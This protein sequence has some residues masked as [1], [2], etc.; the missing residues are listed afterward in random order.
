ML[1]DGAKDFLPKQFALYCFFFKAKPIPHDINKARQTL[2]HSIRAQFLQSAHN[3]KKGS[4]IMLNHETIFNTPKMRSV[5]P[6]VR[7]VRIALVC[8]VIMLFQFASISKSYCKPT[9][10][11]SYTID[12]TVKFGPNMTM[13]KKQMMVELR[14][15]KPG[16][17]KGVSTKYFRGNSG[18]VSFTNISAGS[19]FI[20]IGNGD[21]VA[22]GPVRHFS[23]DEEIHTTVTV[24]ITR[25][26]VSTRSRSS[27]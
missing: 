9:G 17:S 18:T 6:F 2:E 25:G 14:K 26:N 10:N 7:I 3:D 11:A 5:Q 27:L 24:T 16:K 20:A 22:V 13:G 4:L 12:I 8:V 21:E 1:R 19:Y 23:D 15:G